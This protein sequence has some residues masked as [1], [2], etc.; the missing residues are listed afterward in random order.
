MNTGSSD[1]FL[2]AVFSNFGINNVW[3]SND[4]GTSWGAID[5]N[6]PD[7][8]VRWVVFDPSDNNKLF[9]ATATGVFHTDLVNGGSTVWSPETG[10]PTVQT[11][12]LKIRQS[13]NTLAVATYGRGLFTTVIPT[14]PEVRFTVPSVTFTETTAA[15]IGCRN[16]KDYTIKI[17]IVAPPTGDATVTYNV[18]GGNTATRGVDF[19]FTTNGNFASPS[20][21]HVFSNGVATTKQITLR[22]YDDAEVESPEN[23]TLGFA[24]SG[25]TNAFAGTLNTLNVTINSNDQTPVPFNNTVYTIGSTQFLL[26]NSSAGQ[27]LNAK[28]QHEKR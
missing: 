25:T 23:F 3:Y 9:I 11:T 28:L 10:L 8:P 5:G 13:D 7:M 17:A 21:Q 16:Y 12:M 2:A 24:I 1:Q 27:P 6:L 15:S 14:V 22:I 19:D 26:G 4:G 20:N 18:Q